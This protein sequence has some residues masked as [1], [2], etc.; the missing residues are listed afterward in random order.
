MNYVMAALIGFCVFLSSG[1]AVAAGT[2]E[3]T[4]KVQAADEQKDKDASAGPAAEV[5][6]ADPGNRAS[7]LYIVL[8]A[9]VMVVLV[10]MAV[11]VA[12]KK[13]E[14]EA[15]AAQARIDGEDQQRKSQTKR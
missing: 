15:A 14:E 1:A 9:G 10:K 6:Q 7:L 8:I 11:A 13:M 4:A 2:P 5:M 12:K 3:G